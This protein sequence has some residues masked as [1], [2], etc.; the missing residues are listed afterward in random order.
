MADGYFNIRVKESSE[1]WNTVLTTHDKMRS[2][3]MSQGDCNAPGTMMKA[4]L[5]IFK[6]M[7]YQYLVIYIDDI[8][9]Y[10]RTHEEHVRDLKKV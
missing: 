2:R 10:S 8:I 3:V 5:D 4:M 1:K 9:I 6:D 7:V